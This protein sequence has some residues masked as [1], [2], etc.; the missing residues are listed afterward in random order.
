M[1]THQI[2]CAILSVF[3][4]KNMWVEKEAMTE[5]VHESEVPFWISNNFHN[6]AVQIKTL[7]QQE[8]WFGNYRNR[9]HP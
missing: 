6:A 4:M 3:T 7:I 8:Q 9:C 2:P 1:T 5:K